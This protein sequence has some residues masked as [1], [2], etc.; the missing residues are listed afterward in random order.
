MEK[1][2]GSPAVCDPD[3]SA[4]KISDLC[5]GLISP[6]IT[7]NDDTHPEDITTTM[8]N[9]DDYSD[10][11]SNRGCLVDSGLELSSTAEVLNGY[12][13]TVETQDSDVS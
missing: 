12:I 6:E 1:I 7:Q 5:P 4:L 9:K 3:I 2:S 8:E 11:S 10:V 13:Q